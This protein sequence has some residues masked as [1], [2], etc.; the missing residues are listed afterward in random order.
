MKNQIMK[1]IACMVFAMTLSVSSMVPVPAE[2]LETDIPT[3]GATELVGDYVSSNG[4]DKNISNML[5]GTCM[6]LL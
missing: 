3:A 5:P 6:L 2:E 4:S 1:K